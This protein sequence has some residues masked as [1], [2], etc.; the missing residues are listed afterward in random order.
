MKFGEMT[1]TFRQSKTQN[2][3][4]VT[5]KAY[6]HSFHSRKNL[7]SNDGIVLFASRVEIKFPNLSG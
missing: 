4:S 6:V 7:E 5:S 1:L 2:G 3:L